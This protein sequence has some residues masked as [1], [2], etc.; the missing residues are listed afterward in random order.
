MDTGGGRREVRRAK[1]VDEG[2]RVNAI[3][4]LGH[5]QGNP[6]I[7]N[8]RAVRCATFLSVLFPT[9]YMTNKYFV[10]QVKHLP[11]YREK[12]LLQHF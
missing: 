4:Q 6:W 1:D 9:P 10:N 5:M 7:I 3:A 11:L 2:K 12:L 8:S